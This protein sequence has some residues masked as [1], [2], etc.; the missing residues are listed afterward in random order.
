MSDRL[1]IKDKMAVVFH[2]II[3]GLDG[4][5]GIGA[6]V[7]ISDCAKTI[8]YNILS[9]NDNDV[10]IHSWSVDHETEIKELYNPIKSLF[11]PQEYFGFSGI[12]ASDAPEDGQSFRAISRYISLHRAM[13]LKRDYELE[14]G[15]IYKWVLA[16]RFDLVFFTPLDVSS[17]DPQFMFVCS[18]PHWIASNL[19]HDIVFLSNS[20]NMNVYSN[21]GPELLARAYNPRDAHTS[22]NLKLMNMFNNNRDMIKYGFHRYKDVEIYRTVVRP[23]LNPVGHAYGALETKSRFEELLKQINDNIY[24]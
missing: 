16:L 4:R 12:E 21:F 23:E 5:N 24:I 19:M 9:K 3:G 10:F 2:G 22:T 20:N 6:P 1:P 17:A 15:F 13:E 11:Q 14:Q 8:K 18:E 7:N